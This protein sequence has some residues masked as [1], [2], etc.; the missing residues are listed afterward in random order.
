MVVESGLPETPQPAVDQSGEPGLLL[1]L[2][3]D[4]RLA[5][6]LVGGV[7]TAVSLVVF[8]ILSQLVGISGGDAAEGVR[9]PGVCGT[10]RFHDGLSGLQL[11][12]SPRLLVQAECC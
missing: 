3:R 5:F 8:L 7:N 4:Q 9:R 2:L 1:R 10:A 6:L 11:L 12:P